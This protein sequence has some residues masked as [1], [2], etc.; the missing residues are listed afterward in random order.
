MW[1]DLFKTE[2]KGLLYFCILEDPRKYSTF[3][4]HQVSRECPP[5]R[6]TT[7]ALS[8]PNQAIL[9]T[10]DRPSILIL[11]RTLT[12]PCCSTRRLM[13]T[14]QSRCSPK[15]WTYTH[16]SC[17]RIWGVYVVCVWEREGGN[18]RLNVCIC[19]E[20]YVC[21]C[22]CECVRLIMCN[23]GTLFK[24]KKDTF[25]QKFTFPTER[26]WPQCSCSTLTHMHTNTHSHKWM[27]P[28]HA[29]VWT[30]R[31]KPYL[32]QSR[33][34]SSSLNDSTVSCGWDICFKLHFPSCLLNHRKTQGLDQ[35]HRW[36]L[37]PDFLPQHGARV[38]WARLLHSS[39]SSYTC[40]TVRDWDTHTH[41]H[42]PS[43]TNFI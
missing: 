10:Q 26:H 29:L 23:E 30:H 31:F 28:L 13:H 16:I 33:S 39:L 21:V 6:V 12:R 22:V 35:T 32:F 42:S 40:L 5:C 18:C 37:I 2:G 27:W 36:I 19:L 11:A 8:C 38:L 7:P 9:P 15:D 4:S 20:G 1:K 24:E 34:A 43:H 25:L 3:F 14:P 17:G 41:T